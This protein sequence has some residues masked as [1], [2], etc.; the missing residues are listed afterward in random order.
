MDKATLAVLEDLTT[1][2]EQLEQIIA[3]GSPNYEA[4]R[5]VLQN[6][7]CPESLVVQIV[8]E[9]IEWE[10]D[11]MELNSDYPYGYLIS[12]AVYG[13]QL[14]EVGL[15]QILQHIHDV[16][17]DDIEEFDG[18]SIGNFTSDMFSFQGPNWDFAKQ[19]HLSESGINILIATIDL[20][21]GA[22]EKYAVDE[23]FDW[24]DFPLT[25]YGVGISVVVI[26]AL[27][28]HPKSTPELQK[29]CGDLTRR[30][31]AIQQQIDE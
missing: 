23:E 24:E 8:T 17:A 13:R 14:S 26:G 15:D 27:S 18:E 16:V 30:T 22:I 20:Y 7:N 10:S 5:T 28:E 21:L 3:G 29:K 31:E 6:P 1:S 2:A 11:D 4:V 19:S 25:S 12:D 9:A